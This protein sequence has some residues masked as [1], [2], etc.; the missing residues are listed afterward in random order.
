M[1]IVTDIRVAQFMETVLGKPFIPPYTAMGIEKDGEIIGG[2]IFNHIEDHDAHVSVAGKGFS[3]G[4]MAEVGN[5]SF[6]VLNLQ[7]L[8]AITE[9]PKVVRIAERLGGQIEGLMRN[10]F[11][12]GRDAYIL[13]ILAKDF[14]F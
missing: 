14:R 11:G 7:R 4:F 10:H 6:G 3:R 5:Y 12:E 13:G 9:Q 1:N 8:T 2:V